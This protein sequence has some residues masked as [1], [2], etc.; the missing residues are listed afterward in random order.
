MI[1]YITAQDKE[2]IASHI[3]QNLEQQE[4]KQFFKQN[5]QLYA[6]FYLQNQEKP[7]KPALFR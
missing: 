1:A 7:T 5:H 2:N 6:V 4:S 3:Y